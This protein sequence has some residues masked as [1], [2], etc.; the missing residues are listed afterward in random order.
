MQLYIFH[1]FSRV[2][3]PAQAEKGRR[4]LPLSLAAYGFV[5]PRHGM[6]EGQGMPGQGFLVLRVIPIT[7]VF[8]AKCA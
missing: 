6:V 3:A 7:L 2:T 5:L 8:S 4:R 1:A